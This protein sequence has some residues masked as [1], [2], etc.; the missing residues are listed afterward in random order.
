MRNFS[1]P[2]SQNPSVRRSAMVRSSAFDAMRGLTSPQPVPRLP[3][4]E[5][6]VFPEIA[7][8]QPQRIDGDEFIRHVLS[9]DEDKIRRIEI[10]FQLGVVGR[11]IN[12]IEVHAGLVGRLHLF[13]CHF[14]HL[15]VDL[16]EPGVGQEFLD[17][18]VLAVGVEN[19]VRELAVKKKKRPRNVV[20][21]VKTLGGVE[22]LK[23]W[24]KK[25]LGLGVWGLFSY[26]GGLYSR[27]NRYTIQ[28]D[29]ARALY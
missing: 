22:H 27:R 12:H 4:F 24:E 17:D 7:D 20:W 8:G 11:V 28:S 26:F 9:K 13:E 21:G 16:G 3:S 5:G 6:L 19:S 10:P 2:K 1:S 18:V 14:L 29:F 23:K 15:H 25:I